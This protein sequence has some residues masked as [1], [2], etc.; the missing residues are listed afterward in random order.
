MSLTATTVVVL[1]NP[2]QINP[3]TSAQKR[4]KPPSYNLSLSDDGND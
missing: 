4:A 3:T 1:G 2:A